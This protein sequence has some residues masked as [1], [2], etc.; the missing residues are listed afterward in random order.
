MG[1][2]TNSSGRLEVCGNGVWGNVCNYLEYWGPDNAAVVCHQLGFSEVGKTFLAMVFFQA[3]LSW[4]TCGYVLYIGAFVVAANVFGPV[5]GRIVVGEVHCTGA[6]T[7]LLECSH[8]SIGDHLCGPPLKSEDDVG[9]A[10]SCY[11]MH[12]QSHDD[13]LCI[14]HSYSIFR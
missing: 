4:P 13:E 9:V 8:D 2:V 14:T 1:G 7:E 10:I 3:T 6:E 5:S 12:F 11:G